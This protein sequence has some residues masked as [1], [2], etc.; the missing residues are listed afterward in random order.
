M[1][2]REKNFTE[3]FSLFLQTWNQWFHF[4]RLFIRRWNGDTF[5]RQY[6]IVRMVVFF[7]LELLMQFLLLLLYIYC[8]NALSASTSQNKEHY[9]LANKEWAHW[10][11]SRLILH[12]W[13]W[14]Q[15]GVWIVSLFRLSPFSSFPRYERFLHSLQMIVRIHGATLSVEWNCMRESQSNTPPLHL[16]A[17]LAMVVP[18]DAIVYTRLR[19]QYSQSDL[20]N[21][22]TL[23]RVVILDSRMCAW[24]VIHCIA[25]IWKQR[26]EGLGMLLSIFFVQSST[27]IMI[28]LNTC[29]LSTLQS[30]W[31]QHS[32]TSQNSIPLTL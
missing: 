26:K 20:R 31:T 1:S 10:D 17:L 21:G 16:R 13:Y 12:P 24:R 15:T 23:V 7:K 22:S 19:E 30:E 28:G 29:V 27:I 18:V 5:P 11:H 9:V 25:M 4:R 2:F 3:R 8:E 14:A 6:L 32:V